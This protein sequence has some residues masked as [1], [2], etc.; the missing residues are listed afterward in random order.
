MESALW[1]ASFD[2][3][4]LSC[5]LFWLVMFWCCLG[6]LLLWCGWT[7]ADDDSDFQIPIHLRNI[8]RRRSYMARHQKIRDSRRRNKSLWLQK[9]LSR[10]RNA[11]KFS[12]QFDVCHVKLC[13]WIKD[14]IIKCFFVLFH[15]NNGP[16]KWKRISYLC[17]FSKITGY[18]WLSHMLSGYIWYLSIYEQLIAI[19]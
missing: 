14:F 19:G 2:T 10:D 3:F 9:G 7:D 18:C 16:P 11:T 17:N 6:P 1:K 5:L 8:I 13:V 15:C 4:D 12:H